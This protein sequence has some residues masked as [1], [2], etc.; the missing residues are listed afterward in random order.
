M[1][2]NPQSGSFVEQVAGPSG[3]GLQHLLPAWELPKHAQH[4]QRSLLGPRWLCL[5]CHR[6]CRPCQAAWWQPCNSDFWPTLSTAV[7]FP[8]EESNEQD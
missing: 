4:V 3:R 1:S 7:S 5:K 6:G 8:Q 2:C